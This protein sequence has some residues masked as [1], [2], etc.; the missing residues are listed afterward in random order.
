MASKIQRCVDTI[1]EPLRLPV[2]L[3]DVDLNRLRL[4]PNLLV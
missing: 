3:T 4:R 2:S 1:G